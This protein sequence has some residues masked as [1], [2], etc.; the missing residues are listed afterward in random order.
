MLLM[1]SIDANSNDGKRTYS[2][3][4]DIINIAGEIEIIE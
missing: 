1:V 2:I 4:Q 3:F